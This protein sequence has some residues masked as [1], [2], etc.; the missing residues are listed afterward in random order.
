MG[1][2]F[3]EVKARRSATAELPLLSCSPFLHF[4]PSSTRSTANMAAVNMNDDLEEGPFETSV[5]VNVMMSLLAAY[6]KDKIL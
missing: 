3:I 2:C 1:L 4:Q 6:L 5:H